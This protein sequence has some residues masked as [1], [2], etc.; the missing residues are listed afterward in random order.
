[1]IR[2][3]L[4]CFEFFLKKSMTPSDRN[5]RECQDRNLIRASMTLLMRD[6][7]MNSLTKVS[8]IGYRNVLLLIPFLLLHPRL[9]EITLIHIST[10]FFSAFYFW[11]LTNTCSIHIEHKYHEKAEG[12]SLV[13]IIFSTFLSSSL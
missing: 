3:S 10:C 12:M 4:Y 2:R 13:A 8:T 5:P 11:Q 7:V 9:S 6:F 1:M